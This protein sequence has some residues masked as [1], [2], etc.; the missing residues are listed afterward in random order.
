MALLL[1][2]ASWAGI[3]EI[4][5]GIQVTLTG[6]LTFALLAFVAVMVGKGKRWAFWIFAFIY[7]FGS[8]AFVVSLA[9]LPHEFRALPMSSKLS[10]VTHFALQT[11]ALALL[12]AAS[13]RQWFA[14]HRT[15]QGVAP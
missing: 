15:R 5:G 6:F 8:L 10:G 13:S 11:V 12:L 9:L 7:V 2:I 14:A 4:P 3:R 1:T